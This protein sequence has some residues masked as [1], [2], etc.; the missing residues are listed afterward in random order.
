MSKLKDRADQGAGGDD[1]SKTTQEQSTPLKPPA[2]RPQKQL[3]VSDTVRPP[4]PLP[5]E[6][7]DA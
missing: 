1:S 4:K 2:E 6:G 7:E 3:R 5:D